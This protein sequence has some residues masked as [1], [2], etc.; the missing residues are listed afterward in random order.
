[1]DQRGSGGSGGIKE[2]ESKELRYREQFQKE[3]TYL[4]KE[5]L[6][7]SSVEQTVIP[8]HIQGKYD[9]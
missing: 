7:N 2:L 9:E 1:M 6:L 8:F 3:V 5:E 4:E